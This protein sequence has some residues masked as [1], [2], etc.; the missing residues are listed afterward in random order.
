MS[1]S[2]TLSRSLTLSCSLPPRRSRLL[3]PALPSGIALCQEKYIET[4][5]RRFRLEDRKPI[6]TPMKTG[7]K[8]SLHDSKDYF[9]VSMYQQAVGCLIYVCI[10][11]PDVQYALSR[12]TPLPW[13]TTITADNQGDDQGIDRH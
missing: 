4:L 1:H 12:T 7:L 11:R 3:F 9:D 6:A 5:L 2:C 10:T 13:L 8:L